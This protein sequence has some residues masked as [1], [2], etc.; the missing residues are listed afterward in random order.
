MIDSPEL[1]WIIIQNGPI[2]NTL[3]YPPPL[4]C[5]RKVGRTQPGGRRGNKKDALIQPPL[6]PWERGLRGEVSPS[7]S[8][9]SFGRGGMR[10]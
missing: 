3:F 6:S 9:L 8:P 5:S 2:I 4:P 1:F 7:S 10:G